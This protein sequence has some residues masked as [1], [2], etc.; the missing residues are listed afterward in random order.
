MSIRK[1]T[2]HLNLPKTQHIKMTKAVKKLRMPCYIDE[3]SLIIKTKES[4]PPQ[5]EK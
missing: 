2:A 3:E 5:I 1:E 4:K